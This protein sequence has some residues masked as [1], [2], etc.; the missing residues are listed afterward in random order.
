MRSASTICGALLALLVAASAAAKEEAP[1]GLIGSWRADKIERKGR[2]EP[3]PEGFEM[4][5]EIHREG[6]LVSVMRHK[7]GTTRRDGTWKL[8][9]RRRLRFTVEGRTEEHAFRVDGDTLIL[10]SPRSGERLYMRRD[11]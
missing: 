3:M 9:S 11:R 6:R 10:T 7:Q 4:R 2:V 8:V 5:T 1:K